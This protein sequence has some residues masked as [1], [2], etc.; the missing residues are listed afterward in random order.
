M[1][2]QYLRRKTGQEEHPGWMR[3]DANSVRRGSG[4]RARRWTQDEV[5]FVKLSA[6]GRIG[7]AG[8]AV[9]GVAFGM[10]RYAYGPSAKADRKHNSPSRRRRTLGLPLNQQCSV[11]RL[12]AESGIP[13]PA[14]TLFSSV[15]RA[16]RPSDAAV[17]LRRLTPGVDESDKIRTTTPRPRLRRSLSSPPGTASTND[18]APLWTCWRATRHRE[19]PWLPAI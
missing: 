2:L 10:A 12:T 9:V 13:F 14:I 7:V 17:I 8:A 19:P 18:C 3:L 4:S 6:G 11:R 5:V 16:R 1:A 15:R